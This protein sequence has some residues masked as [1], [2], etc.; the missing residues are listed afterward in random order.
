MGAEFPPAIVARKPCWSRDVAAPSRGKTLEFRAAHDPTGTHEVVVKV[1]L[2]FH[3]G[4]GVAVQRSIRSHVN[5]C[6]RWIP[7]WILLPILSR[8]G[9]ESV[10]KRRV[11]EMEG[12]VEV[13]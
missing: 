3:H 5:S 12:V 2:E 1:V 8:S 7:K 9:E 6:V 13:R 4:H 10:F 11:G